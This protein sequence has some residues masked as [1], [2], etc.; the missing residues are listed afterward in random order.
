MFDDPRFIEVKNEEKLMRVRIKRGTR[1]K[2][3]DALGTVNRMYHVH[4]NVGPRGAEINPL[5][6]S[7]VGFE[8]D[9]APTIESVQI[10]DTNGT[11]IKD[12]ISGSV[13]IVVDAYDRTNLNPERRRLGLY[14]L[15][16][17][18]LKPD[19]SPAPGFDEPRITI[20]FNRLPPDDA[21]TKIAYAAESGITVYGSAKTR[22][23][24][25]VTNTVK[26]GRATS[27][28]WDTSQ[29]P[30]ADYTLRIIAAD[31]SGNE[32][33]EGRDLKVTIK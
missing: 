14:K 21:A 11:Q 12:Q 30:K 17:Q 13:R 7:L 8:D 25:E 26:D 2:V 3:G 24:Y 6:L 29:L 10:F 16:Y 32:A 20:L 5:S 23:L 28:A 15:G 27:G 22:F 19:G 9:I 18:V 33:Q 1:F 31:Y 4:M